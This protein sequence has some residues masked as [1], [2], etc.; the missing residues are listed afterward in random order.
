MEAQEKTEQISVPLLY[1][2]GYSL[3]QGV[4]QHSAVLLYS[5]SSTVVGSSF[6]KYSELDEDL[7]RSFSAHFSLILCW[8]I[9][10]F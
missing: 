5:Y 6:Q 7:V 1:G 8:R 9:H 4:G 3:H 10:T 2:I